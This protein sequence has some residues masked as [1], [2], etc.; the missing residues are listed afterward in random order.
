MAISA[1][2]EA[3][4]AVDASMRALM[5]A[6]VSVD[7]RGR[8]VAEDFSERM[9]NQ[10]IIDITGHRMNPQA[11]LAKL[12]WMTEHQASLLANS[13]YLLC[14]GEYVAARLGVQPLFDRTMAARTLMFDVVAGKW[15]DDILAEAKI[16]KRLLPPVIPSGTKLGTISR[17][18]ASRLGFKIPVDVVAGGHDQA[19]AALGAGILSPDTALYSSGTTEALVAVAS[20]FNVALPER[21][22]TIYPHVAPGKLIAVAGSQNGGRLL[23]WHQALCGAEDLNELLAGL[24]DAPAPQVLLP[25]FAGSGPAIN[26]PGARGAFL[27]LTYESLPSE[28]ARAVLEGI[29]FEQVQ[30]METMKELGIKP[31]LLRAVGGGTRSDAWMQIKADMLGMNLETLACLDA[32]CAGA[33]MLAG[34]GTGTFADAKSAAAAFVRP[35]AIFRPHEE[36]HRLYRTKH[37]ICLELTA[38]LEKHW[39]KLV[40]LESAVNR[41]Q[42]FAA[43]GDA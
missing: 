10:K 7:M 26:Q 28:M 25:Y 8:K 20:E 34:M 31:S 35:K 5:R 19:C 14:F 32:A 33:A 42:R 36:H 23:R 12:L 37:R 13:R 1:Q 29:T 27:N 9:G 16:D 21:N 3:F 15:S 18:A 38:A 22:I 17:N 11:S 2:G 40:E 24:P 30:S 43:K 6:P 39:P 41:L 4:V